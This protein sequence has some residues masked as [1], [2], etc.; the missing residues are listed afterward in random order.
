MVNNTG[1]SLQI[2][3]PEAIAI[4][5]SLAIFLGIYVHVYLVYISTI[6]ALLFLLHKQGILYMFPILFIYQYIL[7][8]IP[9]QHIW[10]VFFLMAI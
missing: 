1:K 6:Y 7:E 10:T 2:S 4:I 9:Y 5:S 3:L 8:I